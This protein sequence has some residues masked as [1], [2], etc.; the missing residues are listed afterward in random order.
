MRL[1][2]RLLTCGVV[3]SGLVGC[4][5]A[6]DSETVE[7]RNHDSGNYDPMKCNSGYF[8]DLD[9]TWTADFGGCIGCSVQNPELALDR[10]E[11]TFATVFFGVNYDG[12]F[13]ARV[14]TG[15]GHVLP[16]GIMPT[17]PLYFE[18]I[19]PSAR[20]DLCRTVLQNNVF[21]NSRCSRASSSPL[22]SLYAVIA[23]NAV[24]SNGPFNAVELEL[25]S[26]PGAIHYME[27][28]EFCS[29]ASVTISERGAGSGGTERF[30]FDSTESAPQP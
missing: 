29:D 14:Q 15:Q 13:R 5:P 23:N 3:C 11:T 26:E 21:V 6:Q 7:N 16:E 8:A 12:I 10:D 2:P 1:L 18:R 20:M 27:L 22:P 24:W 9:A 28:Y 25:Y 19:T 17:I 30:G 4:V